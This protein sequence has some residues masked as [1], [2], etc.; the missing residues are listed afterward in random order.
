[1]IKVAEISKFAAGLT[2]GSNYGIVSDVKTAA[3]K[4]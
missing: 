4:I 2:S 3:D 1:L